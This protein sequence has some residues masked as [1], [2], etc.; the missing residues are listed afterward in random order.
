MK[1][2]FGFVLDLI[3][4]MEKYHFN[5]CK[6]GFALRID[7]LPQH[8]PLKE[9]VIKWEKQFWTKKVNKTD[10]IYYAE[11]D[12]TFAL[13]KPFYKRTK[14]QNFFNKGIRI[15]GDFTCMHGGWYIDPNNMTD[16][17]INYFRTSNS[18]SSWIFDKK[19]NLLEKESNRQYD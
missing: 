17:Q 18:S 10:N 16:E 19:G 3:K 2:G 12:T 1:N 14:F 7:D 6:V 4:T 15:G 8:Y 11:I 13:Y 5:I 9:K